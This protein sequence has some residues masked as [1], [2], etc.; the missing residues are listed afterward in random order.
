MR[1]SAFACIALVL[2]TGCD[3]EARR[4]TKPEGA[5][6]DGGNAF[7]MSEGKRLFRW[8]NCNGCHAGGGGGMGPALMD[9][10]WLYG[11]APEQIFST[12]MDGRPNGMP[13]FRGR[14]PD[15]EAWQLVAYVRSMSALTS[16]I[17][18]PSRGDGL[19]AGKPES[20]RETVVPRVEPPLPP[21]K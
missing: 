12:I 21:R 13:A 8:Y 20:Q 4:L 14:I 10:K 3:R 1:A 11:Y 6:F 18:A 16:K 5:K 19:S 2:V 17:A 9:D 7:E 15:D